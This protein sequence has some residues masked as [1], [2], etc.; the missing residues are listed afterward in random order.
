MPI[1]MDDQ[2]AFGRNI[3][4]ARDSANM[5]R[6]AVAE[7]AEISVEYLGEIERG[8][9]WPTLRVIRAIARATDVSPARF[10]EFDDQE[11]RPLIERVHLALEM[12]T[13]EQQRQA[14]RVIKALFGL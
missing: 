8:E 3:R 10:F 11:T 9:K 12:R 4:A 1:D 5:S 2:V 14:L 6:D 13:P 7:R